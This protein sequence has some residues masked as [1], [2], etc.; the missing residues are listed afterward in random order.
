[1]LNPLVHGEELAP[2]S[3]V[4]KIMPKT[5]TIMKMI[6]AIWAPAGMTCTTLRFLMIDLSSRLSP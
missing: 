4:V 6:V 2:L 3:Y 1:M 5:K